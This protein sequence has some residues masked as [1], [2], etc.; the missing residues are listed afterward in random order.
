MKN[1]TKCPLCKSNSIKVIY[2]G[3][4]MRICE[5]ENCNCLFGVCFNIV[6]YFPFNGYLFTY[7]GS[8]LKALYRW[9]IG[10]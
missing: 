1:K 2:Y 9:I 3:F 8:Y 7:E 4:P 10:V 6:E 5:N